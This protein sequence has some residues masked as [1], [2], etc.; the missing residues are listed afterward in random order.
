MKKYF[1]L[2]ALFALIPNVTY[3]HC[4][5]C[6]VGAGALAVLAASLG[7]SSVVVGVLIGA[8]SLALGFWLSGMVKREYIAFQK[9]ILTALIFL[10][11]VVPIAPFIREYGP[12]YIS[13]I[14]EYGT[15]YAVNLYVVGVIIGAILMYVSPYI[16]A[17]VTRVRERQ[18]PFQGVM[19][20]GGLL[21]VASII[22]QI[23]S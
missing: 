16:S 6:T 7:V 15:T 1:S 13:F 12:L 19:I 22:I 11:T 18:V 4:P 2:F 3:A 8:F 21:I 10:G 20:T 5:L 14:G 17:Y 9:H 23:L